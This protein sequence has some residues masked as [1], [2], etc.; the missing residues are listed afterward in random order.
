MVGH[1]GLD[2]SWE[3]SGAA[4]ETDQA[5]LLRGSIHSRMEEFIVPMLLGLGSAEKI[6]CILELGCPKQCNTTM[7][8]VSANHSAI[9]IPGLQYIP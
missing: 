2:H 7:L 4:S 8:V 6:R 9:T 3:D 5:I 1:D